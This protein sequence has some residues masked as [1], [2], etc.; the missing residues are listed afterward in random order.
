MKTC[1]PHNEEAIAI[2][3]MYLREQDGFVMY[4]GVGVAEVQCTKN[5]PLSC[6]YFQNG[7]ITL[8]EK[9]LCFM[10]SLLL[11]FMRVSKIV[12]CLLEKNINFLN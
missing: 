5:H 2:V 12:F 1:I 7:Y 6:N 3:L 4:E 10:Q 9:E 11:S 8:S